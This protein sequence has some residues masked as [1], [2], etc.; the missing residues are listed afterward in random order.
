MEINFSYGSVVVASSKK[1]EKPCYDTLIDLTTVISSSSHLDSKDFFWLPLAICP[2]QPSLLAG[3]L[4]S[5]QCPHRADISFCWSDNTSVSLCRSPPENVTEDL[6][7]V[8]NASCIFNSWF[9]RFTNFAPS[10]LKLS[11]F[12]VCTLGLFRCILVLS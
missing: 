12:Q 6:L 4:C 2:Y 5:I 9:L 10:K 3:P 8:R 1:F 11:L 7:K